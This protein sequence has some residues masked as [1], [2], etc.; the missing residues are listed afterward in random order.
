MTSTSAEGA[1]LYAQI[2]ETIREEIASGVLKPGEKLLPEEELAVL[3]GASRMT[4]RRGIL[5]LIDEGVLYRRRGVGTFVAHRHIER[6]HNRL[7]SYFD[8]ALAEGF[9][10]K[11]E[12]LSRE[13]IGAKLMV[14]RALGLRENEPIIWVRT[15]RLAD[16]EPLSVHDE[17]VPYRLFPDL[18]EA[19]LST[20]QL[21]EC[22]SDHGFSVKRAVQRVE[23]RLAEEEMAQLLGVEEGAPILYKLRTVYSED[24]TPLEFAI[25][26]N[27]GDRY[28]S[29]NTLTR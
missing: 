1:A 12:V 13:V 17:H 2:R 9:E 19:D 7:V 10:P 26:H 20:R 15:L 24:G 18:L 14:A 22:L 4:I 28:S 29:T 23:A 5:D 27:R 8:A 11:M 21:W 25:C 16:G 3:L 6:D